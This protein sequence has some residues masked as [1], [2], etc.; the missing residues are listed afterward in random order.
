V[1]A[2]VAILIGIALAYRF[3]PKKQEEDAIRASYEAA[4]GGT[5]DGVSAEPAPAHV[6]APGAPVPVRAAYIAPAESR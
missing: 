5:G 4:R 2:I 1:A 6:G 3:F